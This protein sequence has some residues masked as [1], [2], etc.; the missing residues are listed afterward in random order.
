[1]VWA[2]ATPLAKRIRPSVAKIIRLIVESPGENAFLNLS[3]WIR[4]WQESTP[5][6]GSIGGC[7]N[8]RTLT[9]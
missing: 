7:G 6:C 4:L 1:V 2:V 8:W 3:Y 5:T 9:L